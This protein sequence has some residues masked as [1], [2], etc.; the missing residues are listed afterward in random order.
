MNDLKNQVAFI[1]EG[2]DDA[3]NDV[4]IRSIDST[5]RLAQKQFNQWVKQPVEGRTTATLL[6]NMS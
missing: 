3:F 5:L 2:R 4:G 1:T 6:D